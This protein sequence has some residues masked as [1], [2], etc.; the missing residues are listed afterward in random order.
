L[1]LSLLLYGVGGEYTHSDDPDISV[2]NNTSPARRASFP[3]AAQTVRIALY[4]CTRFLLLKWPSP[5]FRFRPVQTI[6]ADDD[7]VRLCVFTH[8]TSSPSSDTTFSRSFAVVASVAPLV[9]TAK[10]TR[11][12]CTYYYVYIIRI[13]YCSGVSGVLKR[14]NI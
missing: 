11:R 8:H 1:L 10:F 3:A 4:H 2:C 9:A 12:R 5:V 13:R 6:A 7:H 14:V